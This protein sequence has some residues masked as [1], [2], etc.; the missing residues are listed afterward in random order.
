MV[1]QPVR[2]Q[3]TSVTVVD[4]VRLRRDRVDPVEAYARAQADLR[5]VSTDRAAVVEFGAEALT[6]ARTSE[7]T[8]PDA[9]APDL[10][11]TLDLE[12]GLFAYESP[13][14][15]E[16]GF[17]PSRQATSS[18]SLARQPLDGGLE[19]TFLRASTNDTLESSFPQVSANTTRDS[20]IAPD[21]AAI[22][23][24]VPV[25]N[26]SGTASRLANDPAS[27]PAATGTVPRTEELSA[28][29]QREV[30]RLAQ[31]ERQARAEE[32]AQRS[33]AGGHADGVQ[34][35]Y[36]VGPNGER[37]VVAAEV[38]LDV[39]PVPGDPA[40]TLR[41]ME[42]IIRAATS[43]SPSISDRNVA[44]EAEQLARRARAELAA[45]R[46]AEAQDF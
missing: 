39:T 15:T 25:D 6:L 13:S 7:T 17:F 1:L 4:E 37:Y 28:Q 41:K 9:T 14:P 38:P 18:E 21:S 2:L 29:D 35:R 3:S 22:V 23:P 20:P 12:L 42:V 11:D 32:R 45:K 33:A 10:F 19:S 27:I 44:A 26:D 8:N 34:L 31:S 43:G 30:E 24:R 46:Y 5:A 16:S 36:E 40:A